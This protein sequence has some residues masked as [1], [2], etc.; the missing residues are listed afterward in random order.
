[1]KNLLRFFLYGFLVVVWSC[2][3][4]RLP[5]S[6][7]CD[8]VATR[9]AGCAHWRLTSRTVNKVEAITPC[10]QGLI[11]TFPGGK[12][13]GQFVLLKDPE[14]CGTGGA[15]GGTY[16]CNNGTVTLSKT[17]TF[18]GFN[19]IGPISQTLSFLSTSSFLIAYTD[20]S[21][22]AVAETYVCAN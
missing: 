9:V 19:P 13:A 17:V 12:L 18:G 22:N 3:D 7:S 14:Y 15:G 11:F 8:D 1:M 4:H 5:P 20:A 10:Q 21:S 6:I 2:A 16:T